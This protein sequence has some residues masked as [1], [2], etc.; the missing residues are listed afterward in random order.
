[1]RPLAA[2]ARHRRSSNVQGGEAMETAGDR[3]A[4]LASLVDEGREIFYRFDLEVRQQHFH[5]F[6][7]ADYDRVLGALHALYRPGMRFLEWGS[8]TGVITIMAD[9]VG[10]EACGIELDRDLVATARELAARYGSRA[11]F[12][13]GSFLPAGYRYRSASGDERLGTIGSGPSGYLDLGMPLDTFDLVFGYPW[14]GEAPLM[15]DL[16]RAYG[17]RDALLL[18]HGSGEV[19]LYRSGRQIPLPGRAGG[20]GA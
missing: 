7:A 20:P 19:E 1:V 2:D 6:V 5:P 17:G 8:A 3:A 11:R 13:C 10:Y 12:A 16:M 4:A 15:L 18:L 9:V 14:S